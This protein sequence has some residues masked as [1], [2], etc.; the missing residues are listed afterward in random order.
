MLG[1]AQRTAAALAKLVA[2]S[3]EQQ[4]QPEQPTEPEPRGVLLT[5]EELR[6]GRTKAYTLVRSGG[7]LIRP[8][9]TP[10]ASPARS[11]RGIR[12]ATRISAE[13]PTPSRRPGEEEVEEKRTRKPNGASTAASVTSTGTDASRSGSATTGR[14]DRRHVMHKDGADV[15][16]KNRELE[17]WIE[18]IEPPPTR[19]KALRA[20]QTAVYK[21]RVPGLGGPQDRSPPAPSSVLRKALHPHDR[22]GS[23]TG[24]GAPGAPNGSDSVRR[25]EEARA[26]RPQPCEDRQGPATGRG[27]DRGMGCGGTEC[28]SSWPR[29]LELGRAN[30]SR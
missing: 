2:L 16:R 29:L 20:Y 4:G 8:N 9:R 28:G 21:Y 5:A 23:Q 1:D 3:A 22:V 19:Y 12:G 11:S 6:I 25:G 7:N 26:H 14:P 17:N 27:R 30:H 15:R 18:N 10:A 13:D 24:D